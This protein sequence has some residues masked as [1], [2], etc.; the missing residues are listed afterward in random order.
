MK[1][2]RILACLAI[3]LGSAANA[4]AQDIKIAL[5]ASRTG[6]FEAYA[7][8]A[9]QGLRLGIDYATQGS[10]KVGDRNIKIIVKDDQL[11]PD[12]ARALIAEAYFDDK[13]DIVIGS[14]SSAT[15]LAMMPIALEAKKLLIADIAAADQITGEKLNRYVFR[16]G[17]NT[18][19]EAIAS[20]LGIAG[21]GVLIATLAQDYAFGRDSV[22]AFKKAA[23]KAGAT[24]VAEEFAPTTT[25]DFTA[26]TVRLIDALKDKPGR[27]VIWVSWIGSSP[28]QKIHAMNPARYG[29]Q[30]ASPATLLPT[31]AAYKNIPNLEGTM[32]YYY[33]L[34]NNP[35]NKW[36]VDEHKKRYASIPDAGTVLAFNAALAAVQAIRKAGGTDVEKLIGALEGASIDTPNGPIT[37]RAEDHQALHGMYQVRFKTVEGVEWAVPELIRAVSAKEIDTPLYK[38]TP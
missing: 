25:T 36:L 16:T 31:M 37:I 32:I 38:R 35:I 24:V 12:R 9:E 20:A 26:A 2:S 3:G 1:L 4:V 10:S 17:R 5:I 28:L 8:Q 7:K 18:G 14:T 30:I 33:D 15:T 29:I 6:A 13:A 34:P 27:K 22:S 21:P 19:Q 23:T 11:K